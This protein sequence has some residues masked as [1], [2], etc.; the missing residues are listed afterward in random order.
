LV[1]E[2]FQHKG[3][4]KWSCKPVTG[5]REGGRKEGWY[6]MPSFFFSIFEIILLI[7]NHTKLIWHCCK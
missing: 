2:D 6:G 5:G 1:R 4:N 7:F 3:E